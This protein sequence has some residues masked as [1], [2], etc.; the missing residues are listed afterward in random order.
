M[1]PNDSGSGELGF[2]HVTFPVGILEHRAP[3][4]LVEYFDAAHVVVL[5]SNGTAPI[6]PW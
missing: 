6:T 1:N 3:N 2:S 4:W 5:N